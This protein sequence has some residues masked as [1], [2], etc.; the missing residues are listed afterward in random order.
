LENEVQKAL[1]QR[2]EETRATMESQTA[3][4]KKLEEHNQCFKETISFLEAEVAN[5]K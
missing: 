5:L 2:N 1:K 4:L 3:Q